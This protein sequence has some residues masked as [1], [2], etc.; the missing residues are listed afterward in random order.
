MGELNYKL[1]SSDSELKAAFEVRWQVFVKEQNISE[2][3]TF[4]GHDRQALHMVVM[5][6]ERAIGTARVLFLSNNQAKLERMAILKPFR[7][8]GIGRRIICY[9]IEELNKRQVEQ[10][11]LHAQYAVVAFYK[12]CGFEESGLPFCEAG[13]KHV[14]MQ[15]RLRLI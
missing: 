6:G 10:V 1:V 9:L 14:K 8:R 13:I 11:V 2:D 4:D 12:S 7:R 3:L 5:D 15:R